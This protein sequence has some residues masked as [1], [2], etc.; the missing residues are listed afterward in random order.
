MATLRVPPGL[1]TKGTKLWRE[2]NKDH[3]FGPA[4]LVLV[5]EA[6][7]M[8]DRL[9]R[10]NALLVG[11]DDAWMRIRS[12]NDDGSIIAVVV[13]DA[14]SEARQQANVLKQI[15]AAL[16]IPDVAT[17]A[18][19]QHRGAARGA[20]SSTGKAVAKKAAGGGVVSS[21]DRARAAREA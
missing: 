2:L 10:L 8:A 9:D 18:K 14:L 11:D 5:E 19:P 6:C 13:N 16:R 17:G 4:E 21:L 15:I 12:L 20:Y 7:R 3:T 1:G